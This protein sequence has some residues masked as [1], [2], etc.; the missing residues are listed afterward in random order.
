[1]ATKCRSKCARI[2]VFAVAGVALA[3][4]V[5]MALWNVLTPD[6][7]GWKPIGYLQALGILVLSRILFGGFR[8]HCGPGHFRERMA[9]RLEHMTPE[10]RE[11]FRAGMRAKWCGCGSSGAPETDASGADKA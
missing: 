3:G 2:A 8:G 5:V 4:L 9:A 7:F 11:R 1:M 10:E 6:L